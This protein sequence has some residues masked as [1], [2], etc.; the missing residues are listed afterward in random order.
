MGF[1]YIDGQE[2]RMDCFFMVALRGRHQRWVGNKD[3]RRTQD[4]FCQSE[5][6]MKGGTVDM[7][8]S[9]GLCG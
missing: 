3:V 4:G 1:K 5:A 6:G 7:C 8:I 2:S 9:L